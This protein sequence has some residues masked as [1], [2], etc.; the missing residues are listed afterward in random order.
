M[1]SKLNIRKLVLWLI[2]IMIISFALSG[3]LFIITGGVSFTEN[4]NNYRTFDEEKTFKMENIEEINVNVTSTDLN[5][6]PTDDNNIKVHFHGK[7]NTIKSG[8]KNIVDAEINGNILNIDVDFDK[9][10]IFG[11]G[12]GLTNNTELDIYIPKNYNKNITINSSSSD[13]IIKDLNINS[14]NCKS[15][16][17]DINL[18]SLITKKSNFKTSSGDIISKDFSGDLIANSTSG[19]ISMDYKDFYND[20]EIETTSGDVGLVFPKEPKFYLKVKTTSGD[21]VNE[22]PITIAGETKE[23]Y[24]E[25]N[26]GDSENKIS[27][28]TVSG[29]VELNSK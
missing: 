12:I 16:S 1:K 3:I 11:I 17:G 20:L 5:F 6:I 7:S 28:K 19:D 18:D 2:G 8:G 29:D 27:I 4:D 9:E 25:G 13:I 22:I 15:T 24:L 21:I 26:A 23:N 10:I 14:F